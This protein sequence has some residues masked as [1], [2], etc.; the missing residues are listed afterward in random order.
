MCLNLNCNSRVRKRKVLGR[1]SSGSE[2]PQK[3]KPW[4]QEEGWGTSW[5]RGKERKALI[6]NHPIK[7]LFNQHF[8]GRELDLFIFFRRIKTHHAKRSWRI[9]RHVHPKEV[10]RKQQDSVC[11]GS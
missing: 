11:Q 5:S 1:F 8:F 7:T 4:P 3:Q 6:V 10:L 9:R 2:E